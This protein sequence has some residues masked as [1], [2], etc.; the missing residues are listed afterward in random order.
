MLFLRSLLF[1]VAF[2]VNL[3]IVMVFGG[4]PTMLFG[5]DAILELARVWARRTSGCSTRSAES[6]VEFRGVEHL[7]QTRLHHRRQTSID[8]GNLRPDDPGA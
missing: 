5:R 8:L 4:L 3:T 7:S 6:K 2:Y 1:N